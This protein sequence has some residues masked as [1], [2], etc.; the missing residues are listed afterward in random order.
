MSQRNSAVTFQV[1]ATLS[2][3]AEAEWL[4]T[5]ECIRRFS[6]LI[7]PLGE[8]KALC[9]GGWTGPIPTDLP[10]VD[11]T[12]DPLQGAQEAGLNAREFGW[13]PTVPSGGPHH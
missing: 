8:W 10:D 1:A 5:A 12:P 6:P 4:R 11:P 3:V 13:F 2:T 9:E 7:G